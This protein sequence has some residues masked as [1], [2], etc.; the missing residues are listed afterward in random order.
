[1]APG[2]AFTPEQAD[3]LERA[4]QAAQSQSGIR[5]AV[6]IGGLGDDPLLTAERLLGGLADGHDDEAVLIAVS[7]GQRFVQIVTTPAARKRV[8]DAAAGLATLAMTSSFALGDLVGGVVTG[9][10]QLADA[11]GAPA[12]VRVPAGHAAARR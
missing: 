1:M 11:A 4:R 6:R 8:S 9:L 7:P 2:E 5:F 10:R 12:A 3:R